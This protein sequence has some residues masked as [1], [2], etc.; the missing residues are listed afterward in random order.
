MSLMKVLG[1]EEKEISSILLNIYTPIVVVVYFLSV[2]AG[3]FLLKGLMSYLAKVMSIA[4][5]VSITWIQV[6]I[7]LVILLIVYFA[8]LFISR[9]NLRRISLSEALKQE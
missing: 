4:F 1:Y 2:V 9:R 7:G 6:V 8:C 3:I 5:P